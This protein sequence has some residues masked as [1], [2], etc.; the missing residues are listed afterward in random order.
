MI[1]SLGLVLLGEIGEVNDSGLCVD[2]VLSDLS[3]DAADAIEKPRV[4]GGIRTGNL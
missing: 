4:D 1:C 2:D 3:M